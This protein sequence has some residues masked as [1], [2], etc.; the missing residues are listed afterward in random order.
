M[1]ATKEADLAEGASVESVRDCV[2]QLSVIRRRS[3]RAAPGDAAASGGSESQAD[4]TPADS[5]DSQ[6]KRRAWLM[7]SCAM[8]VNPKSM[9]SKGPEYGLPE[10]GRRSAVG[11]ACI[12]GRLLRIT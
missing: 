7:A 1:R 2:K 6:R 10:L 12:R 9:V 8:G 4:A 3:S 11:T 5:A